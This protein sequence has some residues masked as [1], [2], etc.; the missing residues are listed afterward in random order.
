MT[1]FAFEHVFR[2]A[3]PA[4]VIAAY[5]DADHQREQDRRV[6]IAEREIL[7]FEDTAETVRR[8]CR[9]VPRRRLPAI[10]RPLVS[11]PLHYLEKVIWTKA[12]DE[13]AIEIRPSLLGGR[14]LITARYRLTTAGSGLIKRSYAGQVSVDVALLSARIERGIVAEF[15]RSIP[16]AAACTQDWLDRA[17][18][19]SDRSVA[20]RA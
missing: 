8:V 12:T 4:D 5:F 17:G 11:G 13:L 18:G 16:V 15:Q 1:P 9:V 2:A 3:S 10:V 14:A 19:R 7:S 6:E 20:A